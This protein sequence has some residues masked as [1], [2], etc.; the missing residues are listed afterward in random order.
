MSWFGRG[1]LAKMLPAFA[2]K[3]V[4]NLQFRPLRPH[5]MEPGPEANW[6]PKGVP[7]ITGY[8]Q[9]APGSRP[10][11]RIPRVESSDEVFENNYY[12]RDTR[13]AVRDR[14]VIMAGK[15]LAPGERAAIEARDAP[16][17]EGEDAPGAVNLGSKG[18][19][20]QM[21]PVGRYS[22][23]GLRSA[24]TATHEA[25]A[26]AIK[27]QDADQLV[28]YAWEKDADAIL[29]DLQAKGLP[30]NPGK[31]FEWKHPESRNRAMW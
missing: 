14:A 28:H 4:H 30:P 26:K 23:D 10:I 25:L 9:P 31:P 13:R 6:V 1:K 17:A 5:T 20:G 16:V 18:G 7:R 22:P 12:S 19:F 15:H 8:R 24:M 27:T 29:A 2:E 21:T 3:W 11:A